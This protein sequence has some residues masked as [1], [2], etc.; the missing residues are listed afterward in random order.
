MPENPYEFS[1]R[2]L[3]DAARKLKLTQRDIAKA[4]GLSTRTVN[5]V[6]NAPGRADVRQSTLEVIAKVVGLAIPSAG[7]APDPL[8]VIDLPPQKLINA[9]HACPDLFAMLEIASDTREK[10]ALLERMAKINAPRTT[11]V[12]LRSNDL[13]F[14]WIGDGIRWAGNHVRG[15]RVLDLADAAVATAA[16]ERY[17]KALITND[18]VFQYV[19]TPL[20]LEFVALTVPT[21]VRT[22]PG[23]VTITALG[24]PQF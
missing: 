3:L 17:W 8:L 11:S 15:S 24:R 20:G 6:F 9:R 10:S 21:D 22:L 14:D 5:R 4:T 1:G 19:R 16:A 2:D 12:S 23:L 13:F 7:H 18:P